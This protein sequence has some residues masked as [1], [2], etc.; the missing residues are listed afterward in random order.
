MILEENYTL[1]NGVEIPK[2]GL[3]TWMIDND[4]VAEVVKD[5]LEIG[6]RHIDTAQAYQNESGVGDGI[7]ESDIVREDIF[8]TTKIAAELKS[9]GEAAASIDESLKKMGLEYIDLIIIHSPKPWAEF[10]G[11]DHYLEGNKEVWKALEEAYQ[12]GKVKAI[13]LSNFEKV[14]VENILEYCTVKPMV[15][16]VLAHISNT[17]HD[18]IQY[19]ED[20]DIL[21]EAY[22]PMGHGELFKNEK[23]KEMAEKYDV[24][25][26]QLCIRYGLQLGLLPLPKSG[27]PEH[28]KSNA[29]VDFSISE[30]DMEFLKNMEKIEDY[31]DAS[32]FPVYGGEM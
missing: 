23:V 11:E 4:E 7:K 1:S 21:V 3:G 20:N 14:D 5:A 2:L 24:S 29:E 25:I 26:P 19:S 6:Y 10:H 16:Q 8:V 13:G 31:G 18:L 9:Y 15:N 27:N 28:I 32:V 22:S 17:P 30:E 12:A